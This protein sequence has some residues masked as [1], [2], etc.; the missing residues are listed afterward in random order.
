MACASHGT[1]LIPKRE[2]LQLA[3]CK[4]A[5]FEVQQGDLKKT[6]ALAVKPV[7]R[8]QQD[9]LTP[10]IAHPICFSHRGRAL[11]A[12]P[13]HSDS[14]G[15]HHSEKHGGTKLL[16]VTVIVFLAH[17]QCHWKDTLLEAGLYK[18]GV[19]LTDWFVY[20]TTVKDKRNGMFSFFYQVVLPLVVTHTSAIVWLCPRSTLHQAY[21]LV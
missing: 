19:G 21:S 18:C 20:Y 17:R 16:A 1:L 15:L 14:I 10:V 13:G 5:L 6:Y 11:N 3:Q 7:A 9:E 2:E 4:R 8:R 12:I